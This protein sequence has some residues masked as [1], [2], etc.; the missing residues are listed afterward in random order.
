M[1]ATTDG[2]RGSTSGEDAADAV[3]SRVLEFPGIEGRASGQKL[4]EE[5]AEAENVAAGVHV[6][7]VAGGLLRAHVGGGADELAGGGEG[8]GAINAGGGGLGD[9][10]VDDLGHGL[11]V[12]FP[13][14][15]VGRLDVAVDHAFLVGVLD[16]EADAEEQF[17]PGGNI[18]VSRVAV[19][20]DFHA[21]HQLHDE[22]RPAGAGG[23]H[24]ENPRDV[25]VVHHG[26]RLA[27]LFEPGEHVFRIHPEADDFQGDAPPHR[28]LLFREIDH[29]AA[30]FTEPGQQAV[31]ADAGARALDGLVGRFVRGVLVRRRGARGRFEELLGLVPPREKALQAAAQ[32]RVAAAGV[33]EEDFPLA[34][35]LDAGQGV[36]E[37][38]L[39]LGRIG[40][41]GFPE[42][43]GGF[44][45]VHFSS[46]RMSKRR[47]RA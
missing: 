20:G 44:T 5:R 29:A 23:T 13:D 11:A 25:R 18:E 31:G 22:I 9:A 37:D 16:G 42:H 32:F 35:Q 14:E 43:G 46:W 6:H 21:V 2:R 34:R 45:G 3:R 4:V 1:A 28:F 12:V 26:Q 39:Q 41:R 15:D 30:S 27:F 19:V 24:V 33:L 47:V 8:V 17:E 38:L 10:E 40:H 36:E 7:A